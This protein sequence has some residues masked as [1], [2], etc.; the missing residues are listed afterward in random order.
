M[1]LLSSC[2]FVLDLI[3]G[4]YNPNTP[5]GSDS[6]SHTHHME[7]QLYEGENCIGQSTTT[8]Y[9]CSNCNKYFIDEQGDNEIAD[10]STLE[11]GHLFV[12]KF[13]DNEHY[14]QCYFCNVEQ[15][16]SRASH[17]SSQWS[18]NSREHYKLCDVCGAT[19]AKGDHDATGACTV[20]GRVD[21]KA[22]C[23]GSY[24]YEQLAT[25]EHGDRMQ[26]LYNKIDDAVASAH[27]NANYNATYRSIGKDEDGNSVS[28][29]A[30]R[31]IDSSDCYI[32]ETEAYIV[33][34]SFKYDHPLY[35]WLDNQCS[36][37]FN[38]NT[39]YAS[40]VI[41]CVVD[42]YA[43]GAL[44]T[45]QND[46]IY[47]QIDAY[48]AQASNQTDQYAI[49]KIFHDNIIDNVNYAFKS[50]GVT[51][52]D[53]AWAHGI[54][55]VFANKSAVCEGYA[56][57]FQLLLN[58]SG[59]NNIYVIGSA[60]DVG[61]AWNLVQLA[62][63]EWYWYD[64]TWDDQPNLPNGR[65]YDYFCKPEGAFADHTVSKVKTGLNYLYDLPQVAT[66][67]YRYVLI[68]NPE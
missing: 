25:L 52:E 58:V 17:F 3:F 4:T 66:S 33:V 47:K 7:Q 8:Y 65:I 18:Y 21:Y 51:A 19:F 26:K 67:E 32:R 42:D 59:I 56:K 43:E 22:A 10:I 14:H 57:A 38:S 11:Q 50:D 20:C 13:D 40:L 61:H 23:S 44:R 9:K 12:V 16:N 2:D 15:E 49:A 35:Y 30:L 34:A 24:G 31:D 63:N 46:I 27:D 54:V 62:N 41:L 45:A 64:L 53:A 55:G 39:Q 29:Y 1:T 37:S 28:S 60:A 5:N 36:V 48:L 68:K 6:P